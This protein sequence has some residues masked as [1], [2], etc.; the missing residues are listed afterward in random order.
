MVGALLQ[1]LENVA[2]AKSWDAIKKGT[3]NVPLRTFFAAVFGTQ[4]AFY[5]A[6]REFMRSLV[7]YSIVTYLFQVPAAA[8]TFSCTKK[9]SYYMRKARWHSGLFSR[10]R[11]V[12]LISVCISSSVF[13]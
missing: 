11:S 7:P 4:D 10:S 5:A 8:H 6:Q 1:L 13:P 9:N 2:T 3:G 12:Y